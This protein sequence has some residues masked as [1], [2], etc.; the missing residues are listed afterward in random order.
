MHKFYG[1]HK[2]DKFLYENIFNNV[3]NKIYIE[4]GACNGSAW[5]KSNTLFFENEFLKIN[6]YST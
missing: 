2:E 3:K 6:Y 1:R 5:S 4:L